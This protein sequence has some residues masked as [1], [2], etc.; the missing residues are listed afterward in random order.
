[1]IDTSKFTKLLF[2]KGIKFYA[3]VPDSCMNEFCNEIN[4][5]KKIENI[6][7]ANEGS[8]VSLGVGYH[9]ITKKIPCI[10]LQNSGMGNATDPLTNLANPEVYN[11]PML[12]M[13]GWRGAP[14]IKDEA[15]HY[16]QGRTINKILKL[17]KIKYL[18][19]KDNKDLKKVSNLINYAKKNSCHVALLVKPK[20]FKNVKKKVIKNKADQHSNISRKDVVLSLLNNVSKRTKIISSVG[21]NSREI[22]QMR[23]EK[24]IKNGKDFLMVGAM[25]HTAMV[26]LA[27]SKFTKESTICV[28]GDG[29]FIMHLGALSL[30]SNHKRNNF[31]YLLI[32]NEA[33]ESIGGQ[34]IKFQNFNIKK[35]SEAMGFKQSYY[36]KSLNKLE[37]L[38]KKFI[39]SSG[40]SFF[41]IKINSGTLK[42]LVRPKNFL[43]IK[44]KFMN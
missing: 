25:G 8:A 28:D 16:I 27:I 42:N 17:Y 29:S 36:T 12:L 43:E 37:V 22:F 33:H 35:I 5:N 3:G 32:D 9:L 40:P 1:M 14:G 30:L 39:K 10:Y 18:I 41:H 13:I 20:T 44:K 23:K 4:N 38:M 15:Q 2:K 34:P 19:L 24:K 11:I 31:K 6:T 21:F 26:S 7:S